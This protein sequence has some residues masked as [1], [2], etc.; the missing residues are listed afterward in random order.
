MGVMMMVAAWGRGDA[1]QQKCLSPKSQSRPQ[2]EYLPF[3]LLP[4]DIWQSPSSFVWYI[5]YMVYHFHFYYNQQIQLK[6]VSRGLSALQRI[7]MLSCFG[8][9]NT[10]HILCN[11]RL[12]HPVQQYVLWYIFRPQWSSIAKRD[13][14]HQAGATQT[15]SGVGYRWDLLIIIIPITYIYIHT[16]NKSITMWPILYCLWPCLCFILHWIKEQ[17]KHTQKPKLTS[18]L[19]TVHKE[20]WVE[21]PTDAIMTLIWGN[22]VSNLWASLH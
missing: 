12:C 19:Y 7:K 3:S 6:G 17:Q 20:C 9:N 18:T 1:L 15:K 14:Q 5:W 4:Y 11:K 10:G 13:K 22:E 21:G 2:S 16:Q 8:I